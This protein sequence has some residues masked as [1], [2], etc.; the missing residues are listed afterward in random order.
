[1]TEVD[2]HQHLV[3]KQRPSTNPDWTVRPKVCPGDHIFE[4]SIKGKWYPYKKKFVK[5][6]MRFVPEGY[7]G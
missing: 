2:N 6:K 4:V 3:N 1:M 7:D 5:G